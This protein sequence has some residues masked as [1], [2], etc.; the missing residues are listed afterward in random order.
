[1][2]RPN[3][4]VS[5]AGFSRGRAVLALVTQGRLLAGCTFLSLMLKLFELFLQLVV[6]RTLLSLTVL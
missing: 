3:G 5:A 4:A 2:S 1:M 6:N